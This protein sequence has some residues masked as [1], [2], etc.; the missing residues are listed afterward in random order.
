MTA[1]AAILRCIL[2]WAMGL[3]PLAG[4]ASA[5]SGRWSARG[6]AGLG[7]AGAVA[8]CSVGLAAA[9]AGLAFRATGGVTLPW[10]LPGGAF[11]VGLDPLS[12]FFLI[13]LF[14]LSD[15]KTYPLTLTV[16]S[17]LTDTTIRWHIMAA[18]SLIRIIPPVAIFTFFQKYIIKGVTS[19]A[20]KG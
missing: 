10:R 8:A 11:S 16:Y 6:S 19:G 9:L 4:A 7:Q 17:L 18:E 1:S 3:L 15:A 20:V 2:L 13:P 12:S 5:W 14:L